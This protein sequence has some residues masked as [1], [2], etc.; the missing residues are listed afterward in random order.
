[1][2]WGQHLISSNLLPHPRITPPLR[3]ERVD[4]ILYRRLDPTFF[5][6]VDSI[7]D[8]GLVFHAIPDRRSG[9]VHYNLHCLSLSLSPPSD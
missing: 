9:G 4:S 6:W 7:V 5:F 3:C 8:I 1:M 2:I